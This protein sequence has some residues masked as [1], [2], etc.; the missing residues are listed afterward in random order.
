[1]SDAFLRNERLLDLLAKRATEGVTSAEQSELD[2][3]L[4]QY[5]DADP[6]LI[7]RIAA[8]VMLAGDLPEEP[9][10]ASLR[11]RVESQAVRELPAATSKVTSIHSRTDER[12]AAATGR[13]AWFAAAACLVLAVIGWWPRLHETIE[14]PVIT[15]TP[16]PP[17]PAEERLALLQEGTA[18]THSEWASTDDPAS[19]GVKGDVVWDNSKQRGYLR[20]S[21]LPA[22]DPK[23]SQYQLWIFDAKRD[24]RYPIDGG[25]FD[26][27]PGATEVVIPI[28]ARLAVNDPAMFAVTIERPGGVVVSGRE[29][30]VALAKVAAG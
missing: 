20:F 4:A 27:P 14:P 25:V 9:L 11:A 30:I 3:L 29:H 10:P 26:I 18:V 12:H 13:F 28:N 17:T 7:D 8:A 2:R 15:Q 19:Q 23:Q 6:Q 1:M 21:G 24:D 5:P 22:N 16:R